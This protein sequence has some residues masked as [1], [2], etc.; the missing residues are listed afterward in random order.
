MT[1]RDE[2]TNSSSI[3]DFNVTAALLTNKIN[4]YKPYKAHNS[5]LSH[6]N[7]SGSSPRFSGISHSTTGSLRNQSKKMISFVLIAIYSTN[8]SRDI[9]FQL[10]GYLD[11]NKGARI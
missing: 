8:H 9:C 6:I 2:R 1:E 11:W 7:S 4:S 3:L 10:Y 5:A